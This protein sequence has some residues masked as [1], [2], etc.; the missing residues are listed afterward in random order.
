MELETNVM[1]LRSELS[2]VVR[3]IMSSISNCHL[4]LKMT[5]AQY[6]EMSVTTN[7]PKDS[8][9][10]GDSHRGVI[11]DPGELFFL[12]SYSSSSSFSAAASPSPSPVL[13]FFEISKLS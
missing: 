11:Q 8:L 6:V 13:H 2:L 9:H 4:N 12:S 10:L 5:S 1:M 7:S 3:K